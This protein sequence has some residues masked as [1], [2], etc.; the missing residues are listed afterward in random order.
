M[1]NQ[2]GIKM[3]GV[4]SLTKKDLHQGPSREMLPESVRKMN[5]EETVCN[6]CG[7]SYLVFS[8]IK[9][10]EK[11]IDKLNKQVEAFKVRHVSTFNRL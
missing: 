3:T 6:F 7:V 2:Q 11:T 10:L 1:K 5:R 9:D 8:E 4:A